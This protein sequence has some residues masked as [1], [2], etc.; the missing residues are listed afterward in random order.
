MNKLLII[1]ISGAFVFFTMCEQNS[2]ELFDPGTLGDLEPGQYIATMDLGS[3]YLEE[4]DNSNSGD[5][6]TIAEKFLDAPVSGDLNGAF[7]GSIQAELKVVTNSGRHDGSGFIKLS[8]GMIFEVEMSGNTVDGKDSGY[9]HGYDT[10]RRKVISG[11]Y[12]EINGSCRGDCSIAL[13]FYLVIEDVD[14]NDQP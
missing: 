2:P 9:L 7:D 12:M 11:R 14:R 4:N 10:S 3:N 5:A 6:V 13:L 8:N 1:L